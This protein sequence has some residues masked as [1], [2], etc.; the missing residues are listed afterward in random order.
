M[1][2]SHVIEGSDTANAFFSQASLCPCAA[3]FPYRKN[4]PIIAPPNLPASPPVV[5]ARVAIELA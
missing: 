2:C 1:I 3:L 4:L 5:K